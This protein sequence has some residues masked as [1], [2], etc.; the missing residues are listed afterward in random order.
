[1]LL[2]FLSMNLNEI[3]FKC[4]VFI[5]MYDTSH[6]NT[7]RSDFCLQIQQY[8][9]IKGYAAILQRNTIINELYKDVLAILLLFNF[10]DADAEHLTK[11]IIKQ[12]INSNKHATKNLNYSLYSHFLIENWNLLSAKLNLANLTDGFIYSNLFCRC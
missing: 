3:W 1:M 5:R 4:Y 2:A 10:F 12:Q 7:L 8:I 11:T 6:T 9:I